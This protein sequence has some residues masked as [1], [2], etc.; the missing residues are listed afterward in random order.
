MNI[1]FHKPNIP[2]SLENINT[3]SI[4]NGWLT[5]GSQVSR[6]EQKLSSYLLYKHVIALNS[7]TA[8][9]HL[10][11]AAKILKKVKNFLRQ[12]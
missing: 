7:C 1:P 6:F 5:T 3:N 8:G 11:L 4:K 12:Y 9:L 2:K 10:A